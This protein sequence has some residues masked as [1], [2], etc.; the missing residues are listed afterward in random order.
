MFLRRSRRRHGNPGKLR[1]CRDAGIASLPLAMTMSLLCKGLGISSTTALGRS[2]EGS[3]MPQERHYLPWRLCA[4]F[5]ILW[6]KSNSNADDDLYLSDFTVS[7]V[8]MH[9]AF[10]LASSVWRGLLLW[11]MFFSLGKRK[12][13]AIRCGIRGGLPDSY[14]ALFS[15][16]TNG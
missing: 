10:F 12:F 14:K 11:L 6:L 16:L 1:L 7:F 2:I 4:H 15:L 8:G 3:A 9:I 5:T 13:S